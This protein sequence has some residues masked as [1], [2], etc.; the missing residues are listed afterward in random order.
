MTPTPYATKGRRVR[1][2]HCTDPW[3]A[4][5]PGSLGTVSLVDDMGTVHVHWDDGSRLGLVPGEDSWVVLP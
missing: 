4:L 5:S 3:T 1:L 2:V